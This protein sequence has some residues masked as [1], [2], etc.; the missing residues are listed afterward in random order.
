[1]ESLQEEIK[2]QLCEDPTCQVWQ[3]IGCVIIPE[4]PME[5]NP[6]LPDFFCCELCRLKRADPFWLTIANP[7]YPVKLAI[8]NIP[9]NG[10]MHYFVSKQSTGCC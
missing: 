5:G 1:M 4:K 6:T 10:N 8:A 7:L 2:A 3:H 9:T